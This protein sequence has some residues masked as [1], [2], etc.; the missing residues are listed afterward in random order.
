MEASYEL[1]F[2]LESLGSIFQALPVTLALTLVPLAVGI[3]IG[4]PFA[5]IRRFHVKYL[6]AFLKYTAAVIKGIPSVLL[7]LMT[8]Y[9]VLKPID[10]LAQTYEFLRPLQQM[11]KIY[12]GVAALSIYAVVQITE[13]IVSALQ[14]VGEGQY[15]AAYSIGM[16][17][18]K[19]LRRIIFPQAFPVALPMLCNNII[20][21][22]K[23]TSIVYLISVND[24]LGAAMNSAAVNFRYL[25]AYIAAAIVYWCM[26]AAVE[27]IFGL[28][29]KRFRRAAGGAA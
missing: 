29:E 17:R 9:L 28:L 26:C 23:T 22:L 21:L 18:I 1:G 2:V 15:E 12:I 27:Q 19:T 25:E 20:G 13:T 7:V 5:V 10:F 8:N 24:I 14:A 3:V 6:A 4:V 16:T 11:N